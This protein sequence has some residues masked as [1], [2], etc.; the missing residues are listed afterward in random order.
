MILQIG[1]A[2]RFS[3]DMDVN[4]RPAVT[5]APSD[6]SI[7]WLASR[8]WD[9]MPI[10]TAVRSVVANGALGEIRILKLTCCCIDS[11]F[12]GFISRDKLRVRRMASDLVTP[13]A[14]LYFLR[15]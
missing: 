8:R 13:R 1:G 14:G 9:A 11:Y 2:G 5:S 4:K 10:N 15:G 12:H 3:K 7:A 6:G